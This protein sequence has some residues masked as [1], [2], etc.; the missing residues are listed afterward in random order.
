MMG[1]ILKLKKSDAKKTLEDGAS[2]ARSSKFFDYSKPEQYAARTKRHGGSFGHPKE[3]TG[4]EQDQNFSQ[5]D[6]VVPKKEMKR[7][8]DYSNT[9]V[10]TRNL[11]TNVSYRRF[12]QSDFNKKCFY[13]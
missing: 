6:T 5:D 12:K 7:K 4:Y 13:Y 11:L 9:K 2:N 3:S 8:K 1:F 10:K